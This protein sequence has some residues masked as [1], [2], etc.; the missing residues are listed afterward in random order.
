MSCGTPVTLDQ[1]GSINTNH[2][3]S[4]VIFILYSL[5]HINFKD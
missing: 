2:A 5:E 1:K 4:I 3:Y